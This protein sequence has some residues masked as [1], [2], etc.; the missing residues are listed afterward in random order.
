MERIIENA[1][2][3][4]RWLLARERLAATQAKRRIAELEFLVDG[5]EGQ[6]RGTE[7]AT[8]VVSQLRAALKSA[9]RKLGARWPRTV[10]LGDAD[11]VV[12]HPEPDPIAVSA[13]AHKHPPG[14]GVTDGVRHQVAQG[15]L[16]Q[17]LAELSA[18]TD[19]I[20]E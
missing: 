4:S 19:L 9:R 6:A 16:D 14:A 13:R 15:A 8:R 7:E 18:A 12:D 3:A 17:A 2:Y 5:L 11:A 1:M 20:F 10:G